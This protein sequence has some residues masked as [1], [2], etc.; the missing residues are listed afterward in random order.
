MYNRLNSFLEKY[1]TLTKERFGL[2]NGKSTKISSQTFTECIQEAL[3]KQYHV[4]SIFL[5]LSEAYDVFY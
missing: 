3:D 4:V 2:K 5:D 1:N